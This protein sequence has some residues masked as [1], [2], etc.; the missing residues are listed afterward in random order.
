MKINEKTK[1]V[2]TIAGCTIVG[3]VLVVAIGSQFAKAPKDT[4][5]LPSSATVVSG[6]NPSIDT[7]ISTG[8]KDIVVKQNT[9][10]TAE[11]IDETPAQ[12]DQLE[13]SI[14]PEVT[15]PA[16]P[17]EEQ[18]TDF[19]QKPDGEKVTGTPKAEDH[20]NV[21]PDADTKK[22]ENEP[23][24]GETKDGKVYLPGFGWV[25]DTG[26]SGTIADDMYENGNKVGEMN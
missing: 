20:D 19:T 21:T 16:E 25:T 3:L 14:Q 7:D 18:K 1:K 4:D 24:G 8:E 13:Q 10:S 9:D 11:T 6:V 2:L 12:T 26:G 17:S 23:Q 5:T 22:K 15:K